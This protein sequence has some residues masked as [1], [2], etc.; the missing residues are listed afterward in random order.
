MTPQL[1]EACTGCT[2][3]N[4]L[5]WAPFLTAAMQEFE[6]IT[7]DRQAAFLAQVAHES[8]LFA[9][10]E[11]DLNYSTVGLLAEFKLHF[12]RVQAVEY[13]H[14]PERIA[15][16]VYAN[17]NGNGDESTGDGW[18][19]RGRG[20]IQITFRDNYAG[21]VHPLGVD[22][23]ADPDA[24]LEP[25][26]AARSAGHFWLTHGYNQEADSSSFRAITRAINGGLNGLNQ[27]INLWARAKKAL[28]VKS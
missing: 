17:R 22:F 7:A 14:Q 1:I 18:K 23:L 5:K 24:L 12:T 25:S 11:E 2:P 21:L 4:A 19:F 6:I 13:A 20:L 16:R 3:G 8:E 15:N 28:G 10:I 27:R 9:V 26:L